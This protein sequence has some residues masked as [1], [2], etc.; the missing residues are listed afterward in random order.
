MSR[1]ATQ[2]MIPID[3]VKYYWNS[4]LC[5]RDRGAGVP[6][7]PRPSPSQQ[8]R[9]VEP[10]FRYICFFYFRVL[11]GLMPLHHVGRTAAVEAAAAA[12]EGGGDEAEVEKTCCGLKEGG[13]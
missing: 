5:L 10:T 7:G 11:R 9:R 3:Y 12:A 6:E 2:L 13:N 1:L 8:P 4:G